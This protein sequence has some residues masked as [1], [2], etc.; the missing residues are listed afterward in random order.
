MKKVLLSLSMLAATVF[1]ANAQGTLIPVYGGGIG[2]IHDSVNSA[3]GF[4][5]FKASATANPPTVVP[6]DWSNMEKVVSGNTFLE[7]SGSGTYYVWGAS[8]GIYTPTGKLKSFGYTGTTSGFVAFSAKAAANKPLSKLKIGF[9]PFSDT[10]KTFS[11]E[12]FEMGAY[13][14]VGTLQ[15]NPGSWKSFNIPFTS[16]YLEDAAG[17]KLDANGATTTDS[18]KF[19]NPTMAQLHDFGQINVILNTQS[20]NYTG[21]ACNPIVTSS[22]VSVDDIYLTQNKLTTVPPIATSTASAASNIGSSVLYPNPTSG[23][24]LANLALQTP[25]NVNVIVTDLMGKQVSTTNLGMVSTVTGVTVLEGNIAST[26]AKGMY[27]VTYVLDGT[28]AKAELIVIK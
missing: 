28:P 19:V 22:D 1:A 13:H 26:L 12:V 23:Q 16:L 7:L 10:L 17:N 25:A 20:C 21:N 24:V 4:A 5:S 6:V 11:C 8:N 27:T 3:N 15:L 2:N 9:I 18:T 14:V